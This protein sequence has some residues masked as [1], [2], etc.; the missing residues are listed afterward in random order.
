MLDA[1]RELEQRVDGGEREAIIARWE[2]GD[3]MLAERDGMARL[4]N[5]RLDEIAD[6]IG[7]SRQELGYRVQFRELY[8]TR[9]ELST[10][11]ESLRSWT[12]IRDSFPRVRSEHFAKNAAG[13]HEGVELSGDDA[14]GD[15]WQLLLGRF[16][17][18]MRDLSAAS[19]DAI[20]TDPPYPEEHLAQWQDLGEAAPYVLRKG[21]VLLV[22][23]GHLLLPEY[24]EA[25][26]AGGLRF[27][28]LYS[29]P[30][31]GSNVR[32]QG[33]K[34]AVSWQPWIALSNGDWP[35]GRIDWHPDTLTESP[36]VKQRYVWEQKWTVAAELTQQFAVPHA[37]VLDPFA[38]TGAYGQAA[39]AVGC[40]WIGIE[41]DPT[42]HKTAADRLR[43]AETLK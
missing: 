40:R 43:D 9:K 20:V 11:V 3:M 17:D 15:G 26:E 4:P 28:W 16:Q 25:L 22:R 33:R 36:R 23:C 34:I 24:I 6:A 42:G 35:S 21:G 27:G 12:D 7:K 1:Y 2:C 38:G 39:L 32:F 8:S 13:E 10:I 14:E 18:R 41:A 37:L 31:P 30:L 19:V 5:R 29:E